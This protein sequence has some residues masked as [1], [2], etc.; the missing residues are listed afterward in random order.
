MG[1]VHTIPFNLIV[2]YHPW[3]YWGWLSAGFTI[4]S[5]VNPSRS[6]VSSHF[7]P[8]LTPKVL[9]PVSLFTFQVYAMC[10]QTH[11]SH[12]SIAIPYCLVKGYNQSQPGGSITP[13]NDRFAT[14]HF[15]QWLKSIEMISNDHVPIVVLVGGI[16][17]PLK[18]RS[19][20]IGMIIPNI[21]Q[22]KSHV[23]ATTN[24]NMS[25][26]TKT[27]SC[28]SGY[29]GFYGSHGLWVYTY[30]SCHGRETGSHCV[31]KVQRL[32]STERWQL[33]PKV[34]SSGHFDIL[35]SSV[36]PPFKTRVFSVQNLWTWWDLTWLNHIKDMK[37]GYHGK[38]NEDV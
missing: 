9:T 5:K 19:S 20:S 29:C 7:D 33:L 10:R 24:Q 22:S 32:G 28:W 30:H 27:S 34:Q 37:W 8:Q 36:T 14:C 21:W 26:E 15:L 25:L 31:T 16:S 38:V 35:T 12:E 17:T 3:W 2:L 1:L 4:A 11:L 23:P 13:Y 6:S 18:N